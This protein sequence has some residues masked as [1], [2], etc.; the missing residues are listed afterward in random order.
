MS[1]CA[2]MN[3]NAD[4][5]RSNNKLQLLDWTDNPELQCYC[6]NSA[7]RCS[8]LQAFI[9]SVCLDQPA[10]WHSCNGSAARHSDKE[11]WTGITGDQMCQSD[12]HVCH[13]HQ[14]M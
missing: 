4:R 13:D 1:R 6:D 9:E 14:T 11:T 10:Q 5:L 2:Q 12:C 3:K 8:A 7:P